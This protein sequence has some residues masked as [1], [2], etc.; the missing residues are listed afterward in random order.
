M[1]IEG[2]DKVLTALAGGID[3]TYTVWSCENGRPLYKREKSPL[4]REHL[5][6]YPVRHPPAGRQC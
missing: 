4:G 2:A 1:K 6:H 5:F 3:G